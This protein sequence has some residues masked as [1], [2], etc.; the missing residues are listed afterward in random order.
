MSYE[1]YEQMLCE[2]GHLRELERSFDEL[3]DWFCDAPWNG[4]K[5]EAPLAA[6]NS[7]DETN[8]EGYGYR[9]PIELTPAVT[10][11]CD[12]GHTHVVCEAT[13][14]LSVT[15]YYRKTTYGAGGAPTFEWISYYE[16]SA[17]DD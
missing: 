10:Q 2:N 15:R 8:G 16:D 13:Y 17:L 3:V 11:V 1:G 5:C 7:V 4:D 9:K 12:M 6:S 14:R